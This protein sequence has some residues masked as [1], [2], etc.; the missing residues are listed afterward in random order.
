LLESQSKQYAFTLSKDDL[1]IQKTENSTL[2]IY[3]KN[4][5]QD[6]EKVLIQIYD[7]NNQLVFE[8]EET[9][10]PNEFTI[11]FDYST[12]NIT[13]LLTLK[14]TKY[15][16]SGAIEVFQRLFD[17]SG[18]V[19]IITPE[20]AILLSIV[21]SIFTLTF[22]GISYAFGW[23]GAISL[24]IALAITALAPSTPALIMIQTLV[25]II[26]VFILIIWQNENSV[27]T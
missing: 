19:G 13:D 12:L 21:I 8:H 11:Y 5:K 24:G 23:F 18:H 27:T 15:K 14:I 7:Q 6:N 9:E 22:V 20:M 16:I 26:L 1:S 25:A 10:N 2:R 4:I 17:K 3:Y